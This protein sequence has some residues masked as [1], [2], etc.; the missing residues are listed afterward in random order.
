MQKSCLNL[1]FFYLWI[2]LFFLTLIQ[3]ICLHLNLNQEKSVDQKWK[4][5]LWS[6]LLTEI[7][8]SYRW[9]FPFTITSNDPKYF[10]VK[11]FFLYLKFLH[12]II[13]YLSFYFKYIQSSSIQFLIIN[14]NQNTNFYTKSKLQRERNYRAHTFFVLI[15][16]PSV[17]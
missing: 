13:F 2:Y 16:K 14:L 15:C 17:Q 4:C 5:Q 8:A 12:G 10:K 1:H 11:I 6:F 7:H 9:L 3:K